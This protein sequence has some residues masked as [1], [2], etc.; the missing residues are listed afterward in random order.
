MNVTHLRVASPAPNGIFVAVDDQRFQYQFT[1]VDGF[2]HA[3]TDVPAAS[4]GDK[5]TPI[6]EDGIKCFSVPGVVQCPTAADARADRCNS[7]R[8][9]SNW[10]RKSCV[11]RADR[12]MC[13]HAPI[14]RHR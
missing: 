4:D 12:Q 5:S 10:Q 1:L 14:I 2:I 7:L 9:A 13:A 8:T 6:E 3:A 11:D